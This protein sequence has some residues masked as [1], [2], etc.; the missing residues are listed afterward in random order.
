MF[1][2]IYIYIHTLLCCMCAYTDICQRKVST[3]H[4][5]FLDL[6]F[7]RPQAIVKAGRRDG[8]AATPS[9]MAHGQWCLDEIWRNHLIW[10]ISNDW[11]KCTLEK[12]KISQNGE[13]RK[14]IY[15]KVPNGRGY[16]IVR[17]RVHIIISTSFAGCCLVE[18]QAL[19]HLAGHTCRP[20][21]KPQHGGNMFWDSTLTKKKGHEIDGMCGYSFSWDGFCWVLKQTAW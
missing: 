2:F 4:I 20:Q 13:V 7:W 17:R 16:V 8:Q 5:D 18:D 14:I 21:R 6:S 10:G 3:S 9:S 12:T 15:S 19:K 1:L 11:E